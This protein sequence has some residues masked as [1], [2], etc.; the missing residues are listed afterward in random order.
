MLLLL[1][2][3]VFLLVCL[4]VYFCYSI[5]VW[6]IKVSQIVNVCVKVRVLGLL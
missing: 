5:T 1:L 2:L 6:S 3:F 4:C